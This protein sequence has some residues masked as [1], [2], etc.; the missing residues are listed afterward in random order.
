MRFLR[1]WRIAGQRRWSTGLVV[2]AAV[3]ALVSFA[4]T[5]VAGGL[6]TGRQIKD[7]SLTSVDLK[8]DRA[9][10]GADV[11]DGS[12]SAEKLSSLPQGAPGTKGSTGL[13]GLDGLDN[14]DYEHI[15]AVPIGPNNDVQVTVPCATGTVIGG[16]ASS[17]FATIRIEESRPLPDGS[18]WKVLIFNQSEVDVDATAWA[19]C[20]GAPR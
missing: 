12:L 16:G 10:T 4:G 5:A 13:K 18:G 14:F 2:A 8:A 20:V 19:I 1:P 15:D 11:R 3:V 6:V 17:R 7:A 9:V